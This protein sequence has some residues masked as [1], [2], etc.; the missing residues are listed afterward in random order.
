[1]SRPLVD[2]MSRR[3]RIPA[4]LVMMQRQMPEDRNNLLHRYEN[5]RTCLVDLKK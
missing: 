5:L 2:G 1:M 3:S 4:F